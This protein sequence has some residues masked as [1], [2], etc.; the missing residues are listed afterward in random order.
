MNLEHEIACN[1]LSAE[2]KMQRTVGNSTGGYIGRSSSGGLELYT[3][4][5][6][7]IILWVDKGSSSFELQS[8]NGYVSDMTAN[9]VSFDIGASSTKMIVD[10][11]EYTSSQIG[12]YYSKS[13]IQLFSH[14]GY[15]NSEGRIY[16]CKLWDNGVMVH[17]LIPVRI[18][19][20]GY[21]FDKITK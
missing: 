11:T 6:G 13:M 7:E 19:Q 9:V 8:N 12:Y 20:V 18:G 21:M 5:S 10:G 17:D 3:S 15:Y 16:Y 2:I 1:G 4:S 14:R